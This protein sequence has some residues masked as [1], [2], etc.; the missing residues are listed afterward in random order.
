MQ[1]V[2]DI[3]NEKD[4]QVLLPLLERLKLVYK[5]LPSKI[6]GDSNKTPEATQL[7]DKY[8]GKL[9]EKV[10]AALQQHIAES[11]KEWERNI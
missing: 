9:S 10:G 2:I 7:S 6:N 11:R 4:L 1:L 8:A 3:K 5:Q